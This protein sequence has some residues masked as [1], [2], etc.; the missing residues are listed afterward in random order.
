MDGE[1]EVGTHGVIL[2]VG[3]HGIMDGTH[4]IHG[5]MDGDTMRDGTLGV[6]VGILVGVVEIGIMEIEIVSIL[7]KDVSLER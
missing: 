7:R 6:A 4:G 1:V 3:T 2:M 5:I